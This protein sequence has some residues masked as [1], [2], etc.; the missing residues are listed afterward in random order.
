MIQ[1]LKPERYNRPKVTMSYL[2]YNIIIVYLEIMYKLFVLDAESG[3]YF[4]PSA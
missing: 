2:S 4:N 3:G 1:K